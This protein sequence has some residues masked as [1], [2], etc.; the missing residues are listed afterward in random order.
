MKNGIFVA[1][2]ANLGD[3]SAQLRT[4][5]QKISARGI[6][7]LSRSGVYET[8][9]W[10]NRDQPAY[11]NQVIQV[12]TALTPPQLMEVLLEIEREMGRDRSAEKRNAPRTMDLDLLFYHQQ[13]LRTPALTLPHP[14]LHER[15]FVLYPLVEVAEPFE[16]PVLKKTVGDLLWVCK[17][18]SE[19]ILL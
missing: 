4:A 7:V 12:A 9:P 11:L 17:D 14:R 18:P 2:G 6:S 1:L 5:I 19:V 13:V 15:N 10:G 16:H 3:R 8:E